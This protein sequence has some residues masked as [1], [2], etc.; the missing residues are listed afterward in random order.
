MYLYNS[1]F[2]LCP[3]QTLYNLEKIY[4]VEHVIEVIY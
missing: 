2:E 3:M 1:F 4:H